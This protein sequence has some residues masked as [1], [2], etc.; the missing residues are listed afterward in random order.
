VPAAALAETHAVLLAC[1]AAAGHTAAQLSATAI[2]TI[3]GRD[4]PLGPSAALQT[5]ASG[6][7]QLRFG[8]TVREENSWRAGLDI[9]TDTALPAGSIIHVTL[10]RLANPGLNY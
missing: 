7:L 1:V 2:I 8:A 3:P 4:G 6:G 5:L 9:A 10:L